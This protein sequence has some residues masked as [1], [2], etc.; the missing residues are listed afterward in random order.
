M[1]PFLLTIIVVFIFTLYSTARSESLDSELAFQKAETYVITASRVMERIDKS[2]SSIT[3][4]TDKQIKQMGAKNLADVIQTVPGFTYRQDSSID[5]ETRGILKDTT[6]GILIMINSH[7]LNDNFTGGAVWTHDNMNLDY[8]ERIEFVRGPGSAL[9]GANAFAGVIN[10]ITKTGKD[11]NGLE[12]KVKTGS[13]HTHQY[14]IV[15]G[16]QWDDLQM[17]MNLNYLTTDGH[18]PFVEQDRQ[19]AIDQFWESIHIPVKASRAPGHAN[20]HE[21][22]YDSFLS[23]AYKGLSIEGKY[24]DRM[25]DQYYTLVHALNSMSTEP[26]EDY[27]LNLKYQYRLTEDVDFYIRG[28]RNHHFF[29]GTYQAYPEGSIAVTPFGPVVMP[30]GYVTFPKNKNN[31]TGFEIQSTYQ[32]SDENTLVFGLNYEDMQ[33]YHVRYKSNFLYTL[34]NNIVVPLDSLYDLTTIQNYNQ[35][36]S[37]TFKALF[38]QDIWDIYENVRITTGCRYDDYSD[39]D[40]SLN[41]RVGMIWSFYPRYHLGLMYGRAFRAPA[42]N[43]LYSQNNPALVGNPDLDAEEIETY[44]FRIHGAWENGITSTITCFY[45]HVYN[46]ID[47]ENE[48]LISVYQNMNQLISQGI[49]LELMYDIGRGSSISGNFTLQESKNRETHEQLWDVPTYKGNIITNF[50]LTQQINWF[51]NWHIQG[52]YKRQHGD[53]RKEHPGFCIVNTSILLKNIIP[54]ISDMECS[55]SVYNLFNQVFTYPSEKFTIPGD[56][57][58]PDRNFLVELTYSF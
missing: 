18:R 37:R 12:T 50:R 44:E 45:N 54:F 33:Q 39:F 35:P 7:P 48:G 2:P 19:T 51:M 17:L 46:E 57:L 3:V 27:Y 31:R 26:S 23:V 56:Y 38:L 30:D 29:Y 5:V 52:G 21:K 36:A 4:V 8:V 43:E 15:F 42:F 1:K 58:M 6:Q 25:K 34:Q 40:D 47:F 16:D 41:P 20:T 24:V 49:E 53:I 22:K 9:Y 55:I 28:Y 13:Y 10:I 32:V 11:I 14:N